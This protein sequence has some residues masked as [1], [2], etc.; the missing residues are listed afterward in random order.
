MNRARRS[1]PLLLVL[2][3]AAPAP[4]AAQSRL[5]PM[6]AGGLIGTGA[7]GYVALGIVTLRARRGQYLFN[8]AD[9][10]GWE[11]AAV[12]AGG[13]TGLALGLW[14]PNRLR[15]TIV[16]TAALGIAG[17]GIG[18]LVGRRLW[19]PPEGKW[20]GGVI[21]GA[22]GVLVGAGVGV[23][24]PRDLLWKDESRTGVPLLVRIPF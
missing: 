16:A 4:S 19:P 17:T 12:L 20:A 24:M 13:G 9:A 1:L 21:G 23:L 22:A 6:A 7:G 8:L 2:A 11:S 18:A 10:F 14:D 5:V 15:N 3:L